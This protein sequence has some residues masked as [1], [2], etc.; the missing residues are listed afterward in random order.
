M[1]FE[2]VVEFD[3]PTKTA[4]EAATALGCEIDQIAKS[5][6]FKTKQGLPVLVVACGGNR[7]DEE[8][9][10][11]IVGQ[12]VEKA[13]ADYCKEVTGY[14]IGGIPPFGHLKPIKT[15]IDEDLRKYK[16]IYAAAGKPNAV[17]KT[18]FEALQRK[19]NGLSVNIKQVKYVTSFSK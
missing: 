12:A 1:I 2:N 16:D 11:M 13:S 14:V 5:I 7:I 10:A 8:K 6:V 4:L 9:V 3:K 17:F 19:T 15:I 18:S